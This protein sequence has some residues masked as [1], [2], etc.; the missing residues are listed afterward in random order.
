MSIELINNIEADL[1]L[2]IEDIIHVLK[3]LRGDLDNIKSEVESLK[4]KKLK[5]PKSAKKVKS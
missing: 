4:C 5:K 2:S 3:T 1:K